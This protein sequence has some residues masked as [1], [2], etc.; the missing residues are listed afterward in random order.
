MQRNALVVLAFPQGTE[1][2]RAIVTGTV[3]WVKGAMCLL[4]CWLQD[5]SEPEEAGNLAH[6][7]GGVRASTT[8]QPGIRLLLHVLRALGCAGPSLPGRG[9]RQAALSFK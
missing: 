1:R 2:V 4:Q 9:D 8:A 7:Q 5:T 3:H 6:P